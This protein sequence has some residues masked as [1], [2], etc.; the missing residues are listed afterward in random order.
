M[1]LPNPRRTECSFLDPSLPRSQ[2]FSRLHRVANVF[3]WP[4]AILSWIL[5]QPECRGQTW[6]L[7][8]L[9]VL[10]EAIQTVTAFSLSFELEDPIRVLLACYWQCE[11]LGVQERPLDSAWHPHPLAAPHK[12]V[13]D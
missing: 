5:T 4:V 13:E 11:L 3:P 7:A 12:R 6:E 2:V 8:S 10:T 9:P 1:I